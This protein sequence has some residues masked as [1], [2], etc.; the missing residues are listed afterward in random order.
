MNKGIER[1]QELFEKIHEINN[2]Q[3]QIWLEYIVFTWQWW[4]GLGLTIIPWILWFLFRKK[5][6]SLRLLTS[7]FFMITISTLLDSLGIQLGFWLYKYEVLPF[8]PAFTPWD[9]SLIPV[10]TMF[11]LQIKPNISP[12]IKGCVFGVVTAFVAEPFFIFIEIYEP[13]TWEHIYSIPIYFILYLI[14][15]RICHGKSYISLS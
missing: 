2:E 12:Y 3:I 10:F 4:I 9:V 15:H 8:I 11:F 14:A 6:S 13:L 7:G 1:I 5:D